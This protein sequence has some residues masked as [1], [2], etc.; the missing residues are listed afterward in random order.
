MG[1][2]SQPEGSADRLMGR[3]GKS[4]SGWGKQQP[5]GTCLVSTEKYAPELL[6]QN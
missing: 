1:Y 4:G 3:P 6:S 2:G 5:Y